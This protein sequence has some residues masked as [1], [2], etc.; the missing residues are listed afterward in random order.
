MRFYNGVKASTGG[1][2]KADRLLR[3]YMKNVNAA[4]RKGEN[5]GGST[6]GVK[7]IGS[8]DGL[9]VIQ[10]R[11]ARQADLRRIFQDEGVGRFG[12]RKESWI[13]KQ[14]DPEVRQKMLD[15]QSGVAEEDL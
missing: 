12:A 8:N 9:Q 2:E 13:A 11:S 3:G 7:S 6:G 15:I 5:Y 14:Y 10:Q 4:R 1:Q